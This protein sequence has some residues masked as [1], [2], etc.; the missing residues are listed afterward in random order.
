MVQRILEK[1][2][3]NTAHASVSASLK[4]HLALVAAANNGTGYTM[5]SGSGY[6]PQTATFAAWASQRNYLASDI[7]FHASA[8][9]A[10]GAPVEWE[11]WDGSTP[12][13]DHFLFG[14]P[15]SPTFDI[16]LGAPVVLQATSSYVYLEPDP[17]T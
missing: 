7:T 12:A 6:A 9:A 11:L 17:E 16:G 8:P 5:V 10:W 14:C 1:S 13:S 2:F 3:K 15:I 4:A